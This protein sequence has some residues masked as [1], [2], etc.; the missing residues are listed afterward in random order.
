MRYPT[1]LIVML[2]AVSAAGCFPIDLDVNAQGEM[3]IPRQEGFVVY[4]PSTGKTTM[5][6]P[7][8]EGKPIFARFSPNGDQVLLVEDF[9]KNYQKDFRFQIM[10]AKG[11]E[12]RSLFKNDRGTVNVH[13]SPDG[14]RLIIVEE[15]TYSED[16]IP[17]LQLIDVKTGKDKLLMSKTASQVRWFADSKRLLMCK[18][19][20][21]NDN[22]YPGQ[23]CILD[24]D[25][26]TTTPLLNVIGDQIYCCAD[27]T[28]DQSKI[29][30]TCS[31]A[32]P[33]D[34]ELKGVYGQPS[35]LFE[36]DIAGKT[37]RG[38]TYRPPAI[39]YARFVQLA[40]DKQFTTINLRGDRLM[41][42]LKPGADKTIADDI[43]SKI[44]GNV[45]ESV[46]AKDQIEKATKEIRELPGHGYQWS[47]N[48]QPDSD[49]SLKA[50]FFR[51][52][53][54]GKRLLLS[55]RAGRYDRPETMDLMVADAGLTSFKT[56]VNDAYSPY[57]SY[58]GGLNFPGWADN[59]HI[60]YL[61]QRLVYGTT[62]K[63][64]ELTIRDADG[65]N[66][67]VVQP[68]LDLS[69][70]ELVENAVKK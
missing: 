6:K 29:L 38:I 41:G 63:A 20:G 8:G 60:M 12:A 21:K 28:K 16:Q 70:L 1:W 46:V 51:F 34:V 44:N 59:D 45:I 39:D 62:A 56:I 52:S 9:G 67:R 24:V 31:Q 26:G 58:G 42:E 7:A 61:T 54:D 43:R 49:D 50:D 65:K 25:A 48:T 53:P 66:P 68:D 30:L 17:R 2:F 33:P 27:F 15:G 55:V 47:F 13:F 69:V 23:V 14:E 4:Q 11:G 35:K 10:P 32:G 57:V 5:L 64:L 18:V 3:L 19:T 22:G 36:Y 40:R 37:L